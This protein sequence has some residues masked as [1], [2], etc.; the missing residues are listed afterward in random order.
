MWPVLSKPSYE[1]VLTES[2]QQTNIYWSL[3]GTSLVWKFQS[4]GNVE[5]NFPL[6]G[7][8]RLLLELY[9]K[10]S[11][12]LIIGRLRVIREEATGGSTV[13]TSNWP[14]QN[15]EYHGYSKAL[16][17]VSLGVILTPK[18]Y[19]GILWHSL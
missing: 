19:Y 7:G 11:I 9:E 10:I 2:K 13:A 3:D 16:F 15:T 17:S 18:V 4:K 5:Q 1:H 12:F 14:I 6:S 8:C